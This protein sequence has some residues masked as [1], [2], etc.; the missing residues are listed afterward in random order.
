MSVHWSVCI[1]FNKFYIFNEFV[2]D[3]DPKII[4]NFLEGFEN[5]I[6]YTFD[7]VDGIRNKF[8][9]SSTNLMSYE[10]FFFNSN[11]CNFREYF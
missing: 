9:S 7:K 10:L 1:D 5:V 6:L 3:F 2:T 8:N 11:W 4:D